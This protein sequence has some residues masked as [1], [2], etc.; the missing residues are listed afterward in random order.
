MRYR[1]IS[2]IVILL[3]VVLQTAAQ[4]LTGRYNR[5]RP[6]VIVCSSET[7]PYEQLD[8]DGKPSGIDIDVMKAVMKQLGLPCTFVVKDPAEAKK[9]LES[10]LADLILSDWHNQGEGLIISENV[11][12]YIRI[13]SDSVAEIH[14][15]GRDRQLMDQLDDQYSRLR[16][17]GELADIEN[18]WAHPERIRHDYSRT[19][20][21]VVAV[22]LLAAVCLYL[23]CCLAR[24][25]VR[26]VIRNTNEVNEMISRALHMGDY[27]V[28]LYDLKKN[29]FT[30]QYGQILPPEGLSL[31]EFT[32]RMHPDQRE[33]FA[34]KMRSM[35][36]GRERH[37]ELKKRWNQGTDEKPRYLDLVGHAICETGDDGRPAYVINAV[38]DVTREVE[39]YHAARDIVHKYEAILSDP[40]VPMSFY[41]SDGVL[42]EH[43]EA[44][45]DLF[46][47]VEDGLFKEIF[48]PRDRKDQ[49]FTRHLYYPEYGIDKYV[50]CHIQPL[51]NAKGKI[52]NYLVTTIS[53]KEAI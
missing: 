2:I 5:Q 43:N 16:E 11:I 45:K 7:P 30:N 13:G 29:R 6:V 39:S 9:A 44:M 4:A 18:R 12:N 28:M 19:A 52:A 26:R 34:Q 48:K 35:L 21:Y 24:K 36:E 20:L 1:Y 22:L 47:G 33:E 51:Y 23:F 40:F 32:Q 3:A 15:I 17:S 10:G 31:E 41:D 42:I 27:D 49:R 37:F 46:G 38:N 8:K 14:V 25:H 53:E 50:E